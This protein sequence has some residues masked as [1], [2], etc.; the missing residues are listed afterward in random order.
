MNESPT[1]YTNGLLAEL[2]A[3]RPS[4]RLA[5]HEARS[6][7]ERQAALLLQ[8]T[9]SE[10]PVSL[11]LFDRLPRVHLQ[12]EHALPQMVAGSSHWT[13]SEW[14]ICLN[15]DQPERRERFT[16][17]HELHH[18]VEHPFRRFENSRDAELLADHFSACVLMPRLAVKRA[19]CSGIQNRAELADL[20]EVSE[21]AMWIRLVKLGL[22]DATRH[23][24]RRERR[25]T[26]YRLGLPR[27][28]RSQ[29]PLCTSIISPGGFE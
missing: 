12:R 18:I 9:A 1:T 17:F 26:Y 6:V 10:M 7:A 15:A 27:P 3:L 28:L 8:R 5:A 29:R 24:C 19:W 2:R 11:D 13:G 23:D 16:A 22:L 14:L 25:R 21:E 4:R 20:F